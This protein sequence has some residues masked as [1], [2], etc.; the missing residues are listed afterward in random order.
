MKLN[1]AALILVMSVAIAGCA[2]GPKFSEVKGALPS[3]AADQG[4]IY[5]YRSGTLVG[6]AIQPS[7]TLN[8]EK[9]GDSVPGGF[10]FTDR[11]PGNYEVA[12]STEVERKATFTL[13]Q[14]QIRYIRMSIGFGIIAGRVHPELVDAAQGESEMLD[15][16]YIGTTPLLK[17]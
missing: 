5:Y 15:T 12:M 6:A 2:S 17:K 10:F 1:L 11:L 9:V 4:R 8:G 16:S 7:V 13:D 3:L 14:G